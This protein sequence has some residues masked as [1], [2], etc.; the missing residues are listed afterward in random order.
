[1]LI[2]ALP[3]EVPFARAG[4]SEMNLSPLRT[5]DGPPTVYWVASAAQSWGRAEEPRPWKTGPRTR[6]PNFDFRAS[7]FPVVG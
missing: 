7:A 2:D 3:T 4:L 6:V 5:R 1:M